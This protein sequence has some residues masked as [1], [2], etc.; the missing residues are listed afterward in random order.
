MAWP[1]VAETLHVPYS[2]GDYQR[3]ITFLDNL[4]DEVG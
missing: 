2:E 3:L 1:S 4:I